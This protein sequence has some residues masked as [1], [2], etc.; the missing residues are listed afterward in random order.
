M[1]FS[2]GMGVLDVPFISHLFSTSTR[3][4]SLGDAFTTSK[5]VTLFQPQGLSLSRPTFKKNYGGREGRVEPP[6]QPSQAT[7]PL[8]PGAKWGT[9]S[10][11]SQNWKSQQVADSGSVEPPRVKRERNTRTK[12]DHPC[13]RERGGISCPQVDPV[14][15]PSSRAQPTPRLTKLACQSTMETKRKCMANQL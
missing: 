11:H 12:T 1:K 9:Q 10:H 7:R 8:G 4:F 3:P 14:G 13:T 15:L 5:A 6:G 2:E